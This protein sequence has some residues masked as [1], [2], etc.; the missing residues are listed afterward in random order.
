MTGMGT[1]DITGNRSP[2]HVSDN[3]ARLNIKSQVGN[4]NRY[5][6]GNRSPSYVSYSEY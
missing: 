6:I 1:E 4:G 3:M 2:S 5:I